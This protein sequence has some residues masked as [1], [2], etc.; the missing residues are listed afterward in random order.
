M[1]GIVPDRRSLIRITREHHI[2]A[3]HRLKHPHISTLSSQGLV[4]TIFHF[5]QHHPPDHTELIQ[6]KQRRGFQNTSAAH[7]GFR[8]AVRSE[9]P[10]RDAKQAMQRR[11]TS[12]NLKRSCSSRRSKQT[13]TS[14]S[15]LTP[16]QHQ[17]LTHPVLS[18]LFLCTS[19]RTLPTQHG[20]GTH[21]SRLASAGRT[22]QN[23]AQSTILRQ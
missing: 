22:R 8:A 10:N 6:S 19:S 13:S 14:C 17:I 12:L 21:R 1:Q 23:H 3:T 7:Q 16:L 18:R 2:F 4:H 11:S 20:Y 9:S 5:P 15:L